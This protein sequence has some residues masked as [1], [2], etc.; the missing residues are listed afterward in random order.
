MVPDWRA[1]FEDWADQIRSGQ[2]YFV[3]WAKALENQ[4]YSDKGFVNDVVDV[5]FKSEF[6]VNE[7]TKVTHI[8]SKE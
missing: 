7:D 3:S 5:G 2:N 1:I 8:V 6:T 4:T